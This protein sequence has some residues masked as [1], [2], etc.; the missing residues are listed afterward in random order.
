MADSPKVL[1]LTGGDIAAS[2]LREA[3][4]PG[5]IRAVRDSIAIGPAPWPVSRSEWCAVR[6]DFHHLPEIVYA[7]DDPLRDVGRWDE[8]VLWFDDCPYDQLAQVMVMTDLARLGRTE[9]ISTVASG[10]HPVAVRLAEL[11]AELFEKRKPAPAAAFPYAA[12]VRAA[13]AAADPNAAMELASGAWS[14][15]PALPAALFRLSEELSPEDGI[16]G[17]VTRVL[18]AARA[19]AGPLG[20]AELMHEAGSREPAGWGCWYGDTHLALVVEELAAAGR[21]GLDR[22]GADPAGIVVHFR[23]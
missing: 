11:A 4:I 20:F 13:V 17:I 9:R 3:G 19:A 10:D 7:A 14:I 6:A 12:R 23:R 5:E 2:R 16:G 8:I 22:K 15:L 1:H 21:L 18:A